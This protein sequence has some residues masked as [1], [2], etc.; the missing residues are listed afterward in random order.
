MLSD[1][2]CFV[3]F[4]CFVCFFVLFVSF[5][6]FLTFDHYYGTLAQ[7]LIDV[8]GVDVVAACIGVKVLPAWPVQ[9]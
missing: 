3:S 6:S 1:G 4:V 7:C 8:F 2:E 5:F 9:R